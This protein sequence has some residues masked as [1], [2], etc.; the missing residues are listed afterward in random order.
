MDCVVVGPTHGLLWL[1]ALA[2]LALASPRIVRD[3][4]GRALLIQILITISAIFETAAALREEYG[5][6]IG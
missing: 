6:G 3:R 5:K 2:V 1:G 4:I